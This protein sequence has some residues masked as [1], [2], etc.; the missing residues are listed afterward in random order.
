MVKKVIG[1]ILIVVVLGALLPVLWP[2]MVGT[3]ADIQAM[4]GGGITD[5]LQAMWPV[6]LII[7]G[8][9]IAAGLIFYALRQFGVM[10]G[11]DSGSSRGRRR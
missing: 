8:I 10:G 2:M 3:D 4:E 7:V 1:V 9:G 5:F 11:G 6:A